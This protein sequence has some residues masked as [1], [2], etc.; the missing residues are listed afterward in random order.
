MREIKIFAHFWT[1][2]KPNYSLKIFTSYINIEQN[3]HFRTTCC[4][5][6]LEKSLGK[7]IFDNC[8]KI[9]AIQGKKT[10]FLK[11]F[12]AEKY[13]NLKILKFIKNLSA[14]FF[15]KSGKPHSDQNLII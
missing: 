9:Q 13:K 11:K 8:P 6:D 12:C 14:V 10:E 2:R 3:D 7:Q 15:S 1:K 5:V 4:L